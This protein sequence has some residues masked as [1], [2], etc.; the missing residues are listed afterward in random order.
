MRRTLFT[1]GF[2]LAFISAIQPVSAQ[3][4][5]NGCVSCHQQAGFYAQYSK[6]YAYYQRYLESPHQLAGVQCNDCHGGNASTNSAQ[7]AHIGVSP[8]NDKNSTLHYLQQPETCGLCHKEKQ[9]QFIQSKHFAALIEHHAA[10][11]C[12]TCHPAMLGRPELRSIVL[13][14][15]RNCHGEGNSDNLPQIADRAEDIFNKINMSAGLLGWTKYYYE[16]NEL[17]NDDQD[18]VRGLENSY[19]DILNLV[20]QFDMQKT[21]DAVIELL[22]KLNEDFER[23]RLDYEQQMD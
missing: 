7:E 15:C 2:I 12:T 18:Y 9:A 5:E 4:A 13:N 11:T 22:K 17:S 21:E 19:A 14:A 1:F 23:V 10:P 3:S 16:S 20:H 6:L 8:M